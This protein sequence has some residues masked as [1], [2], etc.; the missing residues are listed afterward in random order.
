MSHLIKNGTSLLRQENNIFGVKNTYTNVFNTITGFSGP[1]GIALDIANNRYY[2][3]NYTSN[4][5]R[6]MDYTTNAQ[7]ALITGFSGP[8]GIDLDIANNRYYV[9][10]NTS[11]TVFIVSYVLN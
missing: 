5:V 6:I 1:H 11:N 3:C 9:C 7:I 4:T 10:N 8:Y 2:V